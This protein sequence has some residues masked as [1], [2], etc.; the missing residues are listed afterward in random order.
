MSTHVEHK[1]LALSLSLDEA[2][3]PRERVPEKAPASL[4]FLMCKCADSNVPSFQSEWELRAMGTP[5]DILEAACVFAA[6]TV[7][8]DITYGSARAI[9]TPEAYIGRYRTAMANVANHWES[10]VPLLHTRLVFCID[11]GDL[12]DSPYLTALLNETRSRL[13]ALGEDTYELRLTP[14]DTDCSVMLRDLM[15]V[16]LLQAS[17]ADLTVALANVGFLDGLSKRPALAA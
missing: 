1:H 7:G 13:A 17:G 15:E 4:I 2:F 10:L 16:Y 3:A 8:G 11:H 6:G 5:E 9:T 14:G 12:A